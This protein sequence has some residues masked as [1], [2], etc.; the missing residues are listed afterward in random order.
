MADAGA[1]RR[2]AGHHGVRQAREEILHVYQGMVILLES[3]SR[4][5]SSKRDAPTCEAPWQRRRAGCAVAFNAGGGIVAS[6][7]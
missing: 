4:R 3:I 7:I 5:Q 2:C 1:Q 6:S